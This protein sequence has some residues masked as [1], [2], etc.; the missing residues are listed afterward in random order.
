MLLAAALLLAMAPLGAFAASERK[1]IYIGYA[2]VDYMAEEV[3]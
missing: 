1:P 2:V 3:L